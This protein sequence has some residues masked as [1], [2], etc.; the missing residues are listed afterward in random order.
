[1]PDI[2][3]PPTLDG[4]RKN[5]D[6]KMEAVKELIRMSNQAVGIQQATGN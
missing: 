1:M 2:Y 4:V 3:V 6:T 5:I